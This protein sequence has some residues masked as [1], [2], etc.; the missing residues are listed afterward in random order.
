[1]LLSSCVTQRMPASPMLPWPGCSLQKC[2]PFSNQLKDTQTHHVGTHVPCRPQ[3]SESE[4]RQH[5]SSKWR[6]SR[7]AEVGSN[8]RTGFQSYVR[9]EWSEV[10]MESHPETVA[11]FKFYLCPQIPPLAYQQNKKLLNLRKD[12]CSS[13]CGLETYR[14][15]L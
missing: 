14:Q 1:M 10:T 13:S 15:H 5:W 2:S 4:V 12:A 9:E 6:G 7:Q 3:V 11:E 8:H